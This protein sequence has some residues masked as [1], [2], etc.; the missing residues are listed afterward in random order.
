[1]SAARQ[2]P[3]IVIEYLKNRE[4][5]ELKAYPDPGSRDGTPWTIGYG[6]TAGVK[7]GDVITKEQAIIFLAEDLQWVV[8][9]VMKNVK[10]ELN[11]NQFAALL[12]FVFNIGGTAFATSTL[13]R[14]LN[15]GRY[16]RVPSELAR[17]IYN[18]GKKLNGLKVR[19][20]E[21]TDIWN[22]PIPVAVEMAVS[23]SQIENGI[24]EN[25]EKLA[26]TLQEISRTA[27][28]TDQN[29]EMAF[30]VAFGVDLR[31]ALK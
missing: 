11:E 15:E 6:H 23:D 8:R 10:V 12:I 27:M 21:E 29:F 1:M 22:T 2:I 28:I 3:A 14:L 24:D 4:K 17:W 13:V 5:L 9:S 26:N 7:K 16:D 25:V 30:F 19:R 18:D 31:E 20:K